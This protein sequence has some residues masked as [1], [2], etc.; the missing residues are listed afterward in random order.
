MKTIHCKP[1][2]FWKRTFFV[3]LRLALLMPFDCKWNAWV[4]DF[5]AEIEWQKGVLVNKLKG[6]RGN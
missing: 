5:T 4:R 6:T 1:E 3:N 2:P